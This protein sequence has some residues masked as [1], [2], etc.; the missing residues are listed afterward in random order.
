[1]RIF[2]PLTW[3]LAPRGTEFVV[4]W[5]TV[6][7]SGGHPDSIVATATLR[8]VG[9]FSGSLWTTW[10]WSRAFARRFEIGIVRIWPANA[11][12]LQLTVTDQ[13]FKAA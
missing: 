9:A 7:L 5:E 10:R 3:L 1:M 13:T 2:P 6:P 8:K 11:P 12:H 4:H